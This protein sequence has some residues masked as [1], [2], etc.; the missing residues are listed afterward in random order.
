MALKFLVLLILSSCHKPSNAYSD[1]NIQIKESVDVGPNIDVDHDVFVGRK[2]SCSNHEFRKDHVCKTCKNGE[3]ALD[4]CKKR[5][6][7]NPETADDKYVFNGHDISFTRSPGR[8]PFSC[9]MDSTVKT[10]VCFVQAGDPNTWIT[11]Q[12]IGYCTADHAVNNGYLY[13]ASVICQV[14]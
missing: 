13:P 5:Y 10:F 12:F 9:T 3:D 6:G 8:S 7:E 14:P 1:F 4:F 2:D 11:A